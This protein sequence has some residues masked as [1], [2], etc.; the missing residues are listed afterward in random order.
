MPIDRSIIKIGYGILVHGDNLVS[1]LIRRFTDS[2]WNHI[3]ISIGGDDIVEAGFGGV[4]PASLRKY[5]NSKVRII[6]VKDASREEHIKAALLGATKCN[7]KFDYLQ[8][9]WIL[10]TKI[11]GRSW[12]LE[13]LH[14]RNRYIC[15]E[16]YYDS[17]LMVGYILCPGKDISMISPEDIASST[18]IEFVN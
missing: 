1:S 18:L 15:S 7:L 12:L 8:I 2:D 10:L 3:A 11:F 4:R 17:W 5:W 14:R 9:L 13:H 16:L 6:R